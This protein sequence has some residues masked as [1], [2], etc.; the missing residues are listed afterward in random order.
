MS[1]YIDGKKVIGTNPAYTFTLLPVADNTYDIGSTTYYYRNAYFKTAIYATSIVGNWNPSV[2][3]TYTLG[4]SSLGWLGIFL[5]AASGADADIDIIK[6][7]V[8]GTPKLWWD[9]SEDSFAF[10]KGLSL[11]D[12]VLFRLG[13]T[14]DQVFV[15][16]TAV[17]NA[18]TALTGVIIGTPDT[19]A[20]AANSL[21]ISN[22]T[23]DGD[24]LIACNDGG[25]SKQMIFLDGSTGVTHLGKP[26]TASYA[27][28]TG[29]VNVGGILECE[30]AF[31]TG[32]HV[33][34][35]TANY[36]L[37]TAASPFR[38]LEI[39]TGI[40]IETNTANFSIN[41]VITSG[42]AAHTI[43]LRMDSN[44]IFGVGATGDGAG[45]V[46]AL[47]AL[48]YQDMWVTSAKFI[49]TTATDS[50]YYGFKAVDNDGAAGALLEVARVVSA[51]DPYFAF[52]GSQQGKFYNSGLMEL[53]PTAALVLG[54]GE[55]GV[56][57]ATGKTLR[58][59]NLISGAGDDDVAGADLTIAAG[60]G[61]GAG[62]VGQIIF[63]TPIVAAADTVQTLETNLTLDGGTAVF[64]KKVGVG[65]A[66]ALTLATGVIA[67][68]KVY[69]TVT[70]EGGAGAANDALTSAT[71]GVAGDILILSPTTTEAGGNDQISI[72]DGTGAGAFIL[73]AGA[74]FTMDNVDDRIMFI[75]N[76]TEWVEIARSSNG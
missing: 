5:D 13:T 12:D 20:L 64:A 76:G 26:A 53:N 41:S 32:G 60:L 30:G 55:G 40:E 43:K 24:I 73:A 67:I 23:E 62:D 71:G 18:D 59:P 44:D 2:T 38:Y 72:T 50:D 22:V 48:L 39:S 45:G 74:V 36:D 33:T 25:H 27:T 66:T 57:L 69:H 68:T 47:K 34:P 11:P 17:L 52:G 35:L 42:T 65:A 16:R 10:D 56:V 29:D 61:R 46:T 58:A 75:H 63:Q 14:F 9:E 51:D 37:G 3:G 54:T 15:H 19:T 31:Y 1:L 28:N 21:I 70:P 6:L 4:T 7:L 49:C 8:T